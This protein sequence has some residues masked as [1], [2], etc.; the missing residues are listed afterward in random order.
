MPTLGQTTQNHDK[1]KSPSSNKV[2]ELVTLM[3]TTSGN[4]DIL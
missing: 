4:N 2:C 3:C 1:G